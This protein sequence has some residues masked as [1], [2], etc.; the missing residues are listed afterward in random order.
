MRLSAI[1]VA[2]LAAVAQAGVA[3]LNSEYVVEAGKPFELKWGGNTGP[4]TITLKDGPVKAL[5]DV[6]VIDSNDSGTSF[7]WTPPATLP[8]GLYAFEIKDSTGVPNYSPQF[9]FQGTA[10]ATRSSQSVS[11]TSSGSTSTATS[12]STITTGSTTTTSGSSSSTN[13]GS[14]TTKSSTSTSA[15][16]TKPTAT[17]TPPANTN[18]GLSQKS[19]LALVLVTVV[20]LLYFN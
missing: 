18:G 19:P 7:T 10:S 1:L 20:A 2:A 5:V 15:S 3:F 6:M 11:S 14:S 12:T 8:S 17:T 16:T 4:V 9:T 13:S